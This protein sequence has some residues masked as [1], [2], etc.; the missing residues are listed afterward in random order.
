M[1]SP[2]RLREDLERIV[3]SEKLAERTGCAPASGA[4][5]KGL[6]A[7]EELAEKFGRLEEPRETAGRELRRR[8]E[9]SG[10]A[11]SNWNGTRKRY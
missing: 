3:E 2:E 11:Y 10:N 6:M 4:G 9:T 7:Y 1:K 5:G 8:R